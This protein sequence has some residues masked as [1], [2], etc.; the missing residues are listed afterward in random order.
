MRQM[1]RAFVPVLI[2]LSAIL[3]RAAGQDTTAK[4]VY[5]KAVPSVVI[6]F[7]LDDNDQ[8]ISLGT[9]FYIRKNAIATNLHVV[10]GAKKIRAFSVA[11]QKE[12][13]VSG[14]FG[15]DADSDLAVLN[16]DDIGEPLSLATERLEPGDPVYAI[17]NPNG[18]EATLST[19]IVSGLRT[20][21]KTSMYQITA[22]ISPGSSGGP[23]LNGM[24]QVI[25]VATSYVDGGQ[26]LNFA[27]DEKHVGRLLD[28]NPKNTVLPMASLSDAPP[29]RE[30]MR[31]AAVKTVR[32]VSPY[33]WGNLTI[34]KPGYEL[35]WD[36]SL[37]ND[38]DKPVKEV[39]LLILVTDKKSHDLVH[40][41]RRK[42]MLS[43]PPKL[44]LRTHIVEDGLDFQAHTEDWDCEYRILGFSYDE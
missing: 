29:T 35:D 4:V 11:D 26:N 44:A 25:G 2:G 43:V 7:A 27:V 38:G 9:G 10:R 18:L 8:P 37:K 39:D 19:G 20:I 28:S 1:G 31:K 3:G 33:F 22:P 42:I 14:V 24:A 13:K 23:I 16:A 41:V 21:E 40:F 12:R 36:L 17:G 15:L 6:I 34:L 30:E 32:I 5:K